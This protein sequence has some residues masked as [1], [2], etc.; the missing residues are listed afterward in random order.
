MRDAARSA[1]IASARYD[2]PLIALAPLFGLVICGVARALGEATLLSHGVVEGNFFF[3]GMPHY[4][5]TYSFFMGDE[6]LAHFK[7]RKLAFFLGPILI[8]AGML[9]AFVA[10]LG[11]FI[12]SLVVVWNTYHVSRQSSGILSVYRHRSGG[13]NAKEKWPALIALVGSAFGLFLLGIDQ[14][15]IAQLFHGRLLPI[16]H[17]LTP[18]VLAVSVL[19]AIRLAM[20]MARRRATAAEWTFFVSSLLLFTPY[21][22]LKSAVLATT[23]LLSGHYVQYM[24]LLWLINR[25]KYTERSGSLAQRALQAIS[26]RRLSIVGVLVA[27]ALLPF[28]FDRFVHHENWMNFHTAWLNA[29]VLLHFYLDGLFWAFKDPYTRQSLG[30]YLVRYEPL[31]A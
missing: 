29:I 2:L 19:G 7:Q 22:L 8:L 30:P 9:A 14:Q 11:F 1:W 6:N 12:A 15:S 21:L 16:A 20:L 31:A 4:L 27:L 13:D 17:V 3:L 26:S 10:H 23:A 25:R 28:A 18:I 5:S 24:G